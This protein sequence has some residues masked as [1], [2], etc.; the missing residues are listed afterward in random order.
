MEGGMGEVV[1]RA[2]TAKADLLMSGYEEQLGARGVYG[3]SVQYAPRHTW[4]ELAWVGRLRN[5][6]VS[7]ADE[8]A[9]RAA[10]APLGYTLELVPTPGRGFHHR[11]LA[12]YDATGQ[13]LTTLPADAA[14]ALATTFVQHPNPYRVL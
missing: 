12:L 2:G 10:L 6:R 1:L 3:F 14:R 11:L 13:I 5:G 8:D 9:L 7:V 4:Q